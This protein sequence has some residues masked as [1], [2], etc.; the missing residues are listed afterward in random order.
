[1][2]FT[3]DETKREIVLAE[4]EVDFAK[5]RDVFDDVFA[6]YIEDSE[7]SNDDETRFM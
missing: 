6:V 1:M 3:W 7:H 4:H 5:I 2:E